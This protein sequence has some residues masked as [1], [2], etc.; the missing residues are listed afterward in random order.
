MSNSSPKAARALPLADG[1]LAGLV[2]SRALD[3][4]AAIAGRIVARE[5]PI[6][7]A[8]DETEGPV[9]AV[10]GTI[11]LL[12]RDPGTGAFVVA[13]YKTDRVADDAELE[14]RARTYAAQGEVY[15][16][17]VRRALGAEPE[18]RFE[19]WFLHADRI[20]VVEV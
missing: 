4:L 19:L 15:L 10:V 9:G 1:L 3:R 12:Y 17:A 14:D 5:M 6:L 20:L 18:P 7:L 8:G 2:G 11:D 13:D 16:K